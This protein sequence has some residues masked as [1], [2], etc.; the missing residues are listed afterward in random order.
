MPFQYKKILVIGA[1][2]GIGEAL[3]ERFIAKG[4][5]VIVVGR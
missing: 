2:L 4:S 1:T 3:A 5:H